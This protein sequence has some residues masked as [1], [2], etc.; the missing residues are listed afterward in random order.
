[1]RDL[2]LIR[3]NIVVRS[4]GGESITHHREKKKETRK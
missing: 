4:F 1:M 3:M 2:Q